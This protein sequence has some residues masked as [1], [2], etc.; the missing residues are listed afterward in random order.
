MLPELPRRLISQS[1]WIAF[2]AGSSDPNQICYGGSEYPLYSDAYVV[3]ELSDEIGPYALLNAL[4]YSGGNSAAITIILRVFFFEA[5]TI[6]SNRTLPLK[7]VDDGYHGGWF[8]EELAAL[9]SLALGIR[10]KSGDV[11]RRFDGNDP[12]G[13]FE[14]SWTQRIPSLTIRPNQAIIPAPTHVSLDDIRSRLQT[15][16]DLDPGLYK[17]L[18][19][20]AR[21]YQD[22][23]WIAESEPHLAWLLMVSALEIAAS[24]H[25]TL[26]GTPME[27]LEEFQPTLAQMVRSS[28]GDEL[29]HGVADQLKNL[30]S[31]TKKFLLFCEEFC[32]PEPV[33]RP[34]HPY[35]RID[36][37]WPSLKIILKKVYDLRSRALHAGVPFPAPMC[38][39]PDRRDTG[40]PAEKAVTALATQTQG[41]Q[42]VP[43][44]APITLHTFQHFVRGALLGWWDHLA[45]SPEQTE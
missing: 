27:N 7:T 26:R 35:Q 24:A 40:A 19:R 42:W 44:D 2:V 45:K 18:I 36:W 3:G 43:E 16:P 20:A 9:T 30:F 37:D 5:H 11:S 10:L 21:S 17:E 39:H 1:N 25:V 38:T 28:G 41:A 32:P 31:A 13:R 8:S 6:I 15:I 4:P 34:A 23:L 22:A 14:S 12:Y 29:L 33:D